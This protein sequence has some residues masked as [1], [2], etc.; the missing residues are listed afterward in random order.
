M[1]LLFGRILAGITQPV[2]GLLRE[3]DL[4]DRWECTVI[5]SIGHAPSNAILAVNVGV[6]GQPW[7][8][9]ST[10]CVHYEEHN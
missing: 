3:R 9:F 7:R 6:Q 4:F 1:R 8:S 2:D 5:Q 10:R